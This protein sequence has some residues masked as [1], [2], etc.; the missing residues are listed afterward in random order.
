[1]NRNN[2]SHTEDTVVSPTD[3]THHLT[4]DLQLKIL[5]YPWY[6][7]SSSKKKWEEWV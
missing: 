5:W 3:L 1:L 7:F 2:L 4:I 6:G